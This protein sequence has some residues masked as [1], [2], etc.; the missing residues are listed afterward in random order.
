MLKSELI[1]KLETKNPHLSPI[2]AERVVSIVLESITQTLERGARVELRGFG[3][4]VPRYRKARSGRNPRSGEQ[5]SVPE[6]F[7]P[8]FRAGKKLRIKIDA[9]RKSR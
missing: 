9:T 3:T 7:V 2:E 1:K 8:F 6:K 4:F 5:V